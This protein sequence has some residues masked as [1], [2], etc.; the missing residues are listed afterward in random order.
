ME[1]KPIKRRDFLKRISAFFLGIIFVRLEN[2]VGVFKK[3]K[4]E[5]PPLKEAR[6][7]VSKDDFPG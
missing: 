4:S 3:N 5:K 2:L 6:Y 1:T 7:Y